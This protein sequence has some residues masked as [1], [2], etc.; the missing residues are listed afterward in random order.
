[1]QLADVAKFW[2]NAGHGA[3]VFGG[4]EWSARSLGASGEAW[5]RSALDEY[6]KKSV[7]LHVAEDCDGSDRCGLIDLQEFEDN[8]AEVEQ[9]VQSTVVE[10]YFP[11]IWKKDDGMRVP[12]VP[13]VPRVG[14]LLVLM[15]CRVDWWTHSVAC[16]A[17]NCEQV[18]CA[19]H[20]TWGVTKN[21]SL[22]YLCL[23]T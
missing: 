22:V 6:T 7:D 20:A 14:L 19:N 23:R 17:K 16:E 11:Q 15:L 21:E 18:S 8:L 12:D 3:F 2:D 13:G 5:S 9:W 4:E 10:V 1:M